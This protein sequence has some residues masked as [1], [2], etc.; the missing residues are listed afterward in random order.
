MTQ[1]M[2]MCSALD[3]GQKD[4]LHEQR[5][6]LNVVADGCIDC[7]SL[8]PMLSFS[9]EPL[10]PG[11]VFEPMKFCRNGTLAT[12]YTTNDFTGVEQKEEHFQRL[13]QIKLLSCSKS[14]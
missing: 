8:G 12:C 3:Q 2:R 10:T 7:Q 13:L 9:S 5:G 6:E 4:K 11:G 14:H 1:H